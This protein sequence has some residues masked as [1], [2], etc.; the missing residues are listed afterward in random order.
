MKH[1]L[2]LVAWAGFCVACGAAADQLTPD[3]PL[4]LEVA[5]NG[6]TLIIEQVTVPDGKASIRVFL[7]NPDA[8]AE[9]AL[10]EPSYLTTINFFAQEEASDFRIA[11]P[12]GM[13]RKAT[14]VTLVLVAQQPVSVRVGQARLI[15]AQ[16]E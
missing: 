7:G 1:L 5:G 4:T 10:H 6:S 11:L 2:L 9:T 16:A 13:V 15:P 12:K 8:N 14:T 3:K